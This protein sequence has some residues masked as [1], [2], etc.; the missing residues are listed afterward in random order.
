MSSRSRLGMLVSVLVVS[1]FVFG[2]IAVAPATAQGD[3]FVY[4]TTELTPE[5]PT[6]RGEFNLTTSFRNAD[7]STEKYRI[8]SI[9]IRDGPGSSA[10]V[11][12]DV[13]F[14]F[15]NSPSLAPGTMYDRNFSLDFDEAGRHQL[16]VRARLVSSDNEV[17][18]VTHS[19]NI[20]VYR[21]HPR[22][23][24]SAAPTL[25]NEPSSL[26]LTVAN[27]L[28]GT[29]RDVEV[30]LTSP[31]VSFDEPRRI[32]SSIAG[33]E[34]RTF[35]FTSRPESLGQHPV[36]VSLEYT[37]AN[38]THRQVNRSLNVLY[39]TPELE[40]DLDVAAEVATAIPGTT[41]T[42]NLTVAN[43]FEQAIRQFDIQ[44][45]SEGISINQHRRVGTELA[46]GAE[47]TFSFSV[48]RPE[49]GTQPINVT[50]TY[51]T[52]SGIEGQLQTTLT[53]TF[54][55]PANPGKVTLTGVQAV[56]RGNQLEI[57]ATASNVGSSPVQAVVVS[58]G[59]TAAVAPA[60]FF[61]GSIEASDFA[62]FTLTTAVSGNVSAV[63][64]E[65]TYV[66]DGLER[67]ATAEL[68][69]EQ[70]TIQQPTGGSGLP[71]VP[72]GAGILLLVVIGLL[73]YRWRG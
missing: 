62:S 69:V 67:S 34:S 54:D 64:V 38:G 6:T 42:L 4:L 72:I 9:E 43:G 16:F 17:F 2:A 12:D 55:A 70:Q 8:R 37:T 73:G 71:L 3:G 51:T 46:S 32:A 13:D 31:T 21:P 68:R 65:V 36:A 22:I 41:T 66:V 58:I 26:N 45:E 59:E 53:T 48:R 40:G 28:D 50:M 57:S 61:V 56:Q 18:T 30:R 63:P 11:L 23:E 52:A 47:R 49:A 20:T 27:G 60:D 1:G 19:V 24:A 10:S 7:A 15:S 25:P 29:V 39:R 14:S 5:Q 44:L 35:G 33:G